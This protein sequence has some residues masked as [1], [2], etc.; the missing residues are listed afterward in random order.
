MKMKWKSCGSISLSEQE[1]E[2]IFYQPLVSENQRDEQA[3]L[4]QTERKAGTSRDSGFHLC[5]L[6]FDTKKLQLYNY[7]F[8]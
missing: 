6:T 5:K 3:A 4:A 1:I 7:S 8:S 2:H